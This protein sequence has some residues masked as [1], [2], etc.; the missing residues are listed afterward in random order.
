MMTYIAYF[1]GAVNLRVG[2]LLY[3]MA[4]ERS[5]RDDFLAFSNQ[6]IARR[7]AVPLRVITLLAMMAGL[8]RLD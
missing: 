4:H 6:G 7:I 5:G 3:V 8:P 2:V 1:L